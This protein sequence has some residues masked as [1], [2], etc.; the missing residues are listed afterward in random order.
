MA[1][2]TTLSI[3]DM[4]INVRATAPTI[5]AVQMKMVDSPVLSISMM[6][7]HGVNCQNCIFEYFYL[8][9]KKEQVCKKKGLYQ[10]FWCFEGLKNITVHTNTH[11]PTEIYTG[12]A[13]IY[14]IHI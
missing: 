10:W 8:L 14:F 9:S 2:T 11:R 3:I 6:R 4:I 13:S 5:A 7:P 1:M 12:R